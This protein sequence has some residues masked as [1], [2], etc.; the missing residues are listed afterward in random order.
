M[1]GRITA[2]ELVRFKV[3]KISADANVSGNLSVASR[4]HNG[5]GVTVS[6]WVVKRNTG[7]SDTGPINTVSR[8][9]AI[10]TAEREGSK[11]RVWCS[12][13]VMD[14]ITQKMM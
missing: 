2:S 10:I 8:H 9:E 13:G 3:H 6:T 14:Y 1:A 7:I 11:I 12:G 5:L 4:L